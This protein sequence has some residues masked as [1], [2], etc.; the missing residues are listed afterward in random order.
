MVV[1]THSLSHSY[2][3]R[4]PNLSELNLRVPRGSIYGFLGPN[5]SGKTTTLSLLLGLLPPQKGT[6][7]LF[8]ETLHHNRAALLKRTGSLIEAPSLYRHLTARENLE[9]YRAIYGVA[10]SRASE[11]LQLVGLQQERTKAVRSFSLGMKQRLA[12][13]LALMHRPELLVLDEPTNG[14]DPGGIIELRTLIRQLNQEEGMTVLLSSHLLAE[15]EK[16]A[17]HIGVLSGGRL[18]FQGTMPELRSLQ[19]GRSVLH[20]R[21]SDDMAAAKLLQSYHPTMNPDGIS[22]PIA[23]AGQGAAINRLLI[24][25]QLDVHLLHP[26]TPDLEQLFID[27]TNTNA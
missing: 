2:S 7:C 19:A 5:G 8:G 4:V 10:K 14:L 3:G 17:T 18:L 12:I 24:G 25:H 15:V 27:L 9:V 23:H 22:I 20:L 13:A 26:V 11:V 1:E 6:I 16:M 21:T